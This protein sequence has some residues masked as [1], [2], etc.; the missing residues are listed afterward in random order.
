MLTAVRR[1]QCQRIQIDSK[2]TIG[3]F[4][5]GKNT[6]FHPVD[7]PKTSRQ[8][9]TANSTPTKSTSIGSSAKSQ[10]RNSSWKPEPVNAT[11]SRPMTRD[12]DPQTS[13]KSGGTPVDSPTKILRKTNRIPPH[14][15]HHPPNMTLPRTTKIDQIPP[16]STRKQPD[17]NR[18][19]PPSPAWDLTFP[20]ESVYFTA[21]RWELFHREIPAGIASIGRAPHS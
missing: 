13:S 19:L 14:R 16:P 7:E 6:D 2:Q 17:T 11:E 18:Y 12:F 20:Q 4:L 21:P 9:P 3:L 1:Q 5:L 15:P 10:T 8:P